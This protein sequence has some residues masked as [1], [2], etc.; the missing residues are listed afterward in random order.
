MDHI[1][2]PQVT[3][4]DRCLVASLPRCL[5]GAAARRSDGAEPDAARG[6]LVLGLSPVM[7]ACG[8]RRDQCKCVLTYLLS[9]KEI[10]EL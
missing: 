9:S 2:D 8:L 7:S 5:V 3:Q 4:M 1:F 6:G 10:H